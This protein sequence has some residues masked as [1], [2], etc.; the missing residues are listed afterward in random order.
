VASEPLFCP[1]GSAA[2]LCKALTAT[3]RQAPPA[4]GSVNLRPH[5]Q[6]SPDFV[7][8]AQIKHLAHRSLRDAQRVQHQSVLAC[9]LQAGRD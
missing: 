3:W 2:R 9:A 8:D 6:R 4:G 7:A 5:S 1:L